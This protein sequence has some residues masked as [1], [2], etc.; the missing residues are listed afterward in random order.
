MKL[1]VKSLLS[2]VKGPLLKHIT[3]TSRKLLRQLGS[4]IDTVINCQTQVLHNFVFKNT[5]K[6]QLLLVNHNRVQNC[7][8]VT[9]LCVKAASE[10]KFLV[11]PNQ[12]QIL[13]SVHQS[14]I[15]MITFMSVFTT[16]M[17]GCQ[18]N[19]SMKSIINKIQV[20]NSESIQ[21]NYN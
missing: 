17:Q 21:S 13:H 4:G 15:V 7:K 2:K 5:E 10:R 6:S 12:I 11:S 16:H 19:Q 20:H 3:S 14:V 8:P 1:E 18:R 9:F